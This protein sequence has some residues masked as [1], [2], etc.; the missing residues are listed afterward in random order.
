MCFRL[1]F[2]KEIATIDKYYALTDPKTVLTQIEV[3]GE[4]V[5]DEKGIKF[6]TNKYKLIR[7]YTSSEPI[8][9]KDGTKVWYDQGRIHRKEIYRRD[10][11]HRLIRDSL[12][13]VEYPNGTKAWLSAG[14]LHRE[15]E[16]P[17]IEDADGSK[18]WWIEDKRHRGNDLP[19]IEYANGDKEWWTK[20]KRRRENGLPAISI[21]WK[22][23]IDGFQWTENV[24][25]GRDC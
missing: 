6:C 12:P 17:A 13:A 20:G 15:N 4:I 9:L 10:D 18:Q 14:K 8:H 7:Y 16:L 3:L 1:P 24:N 23:P 25:K 19:A 11:K 21:C 5:A 2:C 22:I